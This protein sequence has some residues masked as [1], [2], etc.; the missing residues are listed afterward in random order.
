MKDSSFALF[1]LGTPTGNETIFWFFFTEAWGY[2]KRY[3][4][5]YVSRRFRFC[6]RSSPV[7]RN[8]KPLFAIAGIYRL[9]RTAYSQ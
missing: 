2:S 4:R 5:R 1:C 7:R 8:K 6:L 9:F 3:Y